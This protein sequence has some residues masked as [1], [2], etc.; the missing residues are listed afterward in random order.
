MTR[1]I[2]AA[3]AAVVLLTSTI[4]A[5]AT[6]FNLTATNTKLTFVGTKPQG[7]HDGG[8]KALTGSA[9][10]NGKDLTTLKIAVDIDVN[11]L[12]SDNPK[13][14]NHLKSPDFFSVKSHPTAKFVTTKIEKAGDAYNVTGDLTMLGKTAPVSFPATISISGDS[15]TL[16][17]KFKID[18][19][20]WGMTY[21]Q[22]KVDNDVT[23]TLSVTAKK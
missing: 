13:L 14:T 17:S 19:T 11:S 7:K 2:L 10:V 1:R 22:G 5:G 4:W 20:K 16:A 6:T 8:F 12:Y 3:S 23:L 18:R 15:L 9:S 21:G